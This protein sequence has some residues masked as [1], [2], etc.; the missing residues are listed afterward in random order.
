MA[1][2]ESV[3]PPRSPMKALLSSPSGRKRFREY[4]DNA[5]AS[6]SPNKLLGS[7]SL[8]DKLRAAR[9]DRD[10]EILPIKPEQTDISDDDED[11]EI[12]QLKLQA[13][14]AKLKLKKLQQ[15]KVK[16]REN[17]RPENAKYTDFLGSDPKLEVAL[18]PVKK[19]ASSAE[20]RSPNRVIL[21]IDK[22]L[23]ASD[24]SLKRAHN[25]PTSPM[26][27]R[28]EGGKPVFKGRPSIFT[29]CRPSSSSSSAAP[30][31]P[32]KSFSERMA[33]MRDRD[34]DR[35][36]KDSA[37][38][39][40]RSSHFNV[41]K[42]EMTRYHEASEDATTHNS[43]SERDIRKPVERSIKHSHS[44]PSLRS[45]PSN[46]TQHGISKAI[47]S[48]DNKKGDPSLFEAFS[49]TALSSRILPHSF[50]KRTM[51][52][53][54]FTVY[55]VPSLLKNITSPAYEIPDGVGDYVVFGIIANI[56]NPRS[57]K[58]NAADNRTSSS[59]DWEKKWN[60]GANN[61][62]KFMVMT[63]TD[64]KWTIDLFLFDTAVPRY[65]RLSIGTL[66]AIL[67]P[68]I[69]PP[70]KGREDTGAFSLTLNN[71]EDQVLEIGKAAHLGHCTAKKKDGQ[72]CKQW[73]DSS[74]TSICEFHLNAQ[75]NRTRGSRAGL[76]STD[77]W[78]SKKPK[79]K[80]QTNKHGFDY[81]SQ[82]FY[83][84]IG[85]TTPQESSGQK[86][87]L[88]ATGNA[89]LSTAKLIDH[90][91]SG[92]PFVD[93]KMLE[94]DKKDRLRRRMDAMSREHEIAKKLAR[95]NGSAGSQYMQSRTAE[96][97]SSSKRTGMNAPEAN[98]GG[99]TKQDILADKIGG[100]SKKRAADSVRLS[101]VR[102]KTRFL[103]DQGIK[104]AGRESIGAGSGGPPQVEQMK[105]TD[106]D[107][108][109]DD[110]D[111]LDIV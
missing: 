70:K 10:H 80:S 50:L 94:R 110:D 57:H 34:T 52:S 89:G 78:Q 90:G 109:D 29:Q 67:N 93:S 84:A 68:G 65:H 8:L 107:T 51:P 111:D 44:M 47:V 59:Q 83:Y 28:Q 1:E 45:V 36:K 72:E 49:G 92:D 43:A 100:Q 86:W 102:K 18:S 22:G 46:S 53:D 71:G 21:G 38:R 55:T 69:M 13:I 74:K 79:E 101:P 6:T 87:A 42:A 99:I 17:T 41:D 25:L 35:E 23:H 98:K 95:F 48:D 16:A 61:N 30:Q 64:L 20:L 24:V 19:I 63:L 108:D 104:V 62:Q 73:I 106:D 85:G 12:L 76:N 2:S 103:T 77:S 5:L 32:S 40:A 26:K 14:Q 82:T 75:I 27:Q 31:A 60:D 56:S 97:G 105:K 81:E 9:A 58:P 91:D 54:Q 4:Q 39:N 33:E 66:V 37:V 96:E 15:E 88:G 11:E 3:W 7:P